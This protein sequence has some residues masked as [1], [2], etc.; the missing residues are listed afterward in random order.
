MK[1]SLRFAPRAG[2]RRATV[3]FASGALA[4]FTLGA[5]VAAG[6]TP[7]A[8]RHVAPR[9][10]YG[11]KSPDALAVDGHDL[12]VANRAGNSVTELTS[13]V[14]SWVRTISA[15][16]YRFNAPT[17]I[18]GDGGHIFVANRGG[19]VTEL[20]AGN[21]SLV[22][23]ISGRKY[24]LS[25]PSAMK[26]DGADLFVVDSGG[27]LTELKTSNGSLVRAISGHFAD[28]TAIAL[29][30]ADLWIVNTGGNSV[31]EIAAKSGKWV[32]TLAAPSFMFNQPAG[33]A[34]DGTDLWVTNPPSNSATE[35]DAASASLVKVVSNSTSSYGFDS[36]S[37]AVSAG[38]L[39]YVAS[40]P[41]ESPMVTAF[42]AKTGPAHWYMC[43]TNG[44]YHFN[45]PSALAV[46]G[47]TLWVANAGTSAFEHRLRDGP[48]ELADGDE[49]HHGHLIRTII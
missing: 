25:A 4:A 5:G 19:S 8:P 6:S 14:G 24:H 23:T 18:V 33:I 29:A 3:V 15:P 49:R 31:T 11:F 35:I 45:N 39:V 34:F 42:A 41:G 47:G 37:A 40:P 13:P 7:R 28:P 43:N 26:L 17:A 10:S 44:P 36:P 30:G 38:S 22:R 16:R 32:R 9:S 20:N 2:V 27:W 21:G 48:G 46:S 12:W 1:R